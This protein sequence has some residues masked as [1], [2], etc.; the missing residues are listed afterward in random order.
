[1]KLIKTIKKIRILRFLQENKNKK[2][3]QGEIARELI[4]ELEYSSVVSARIV[5][6]IYLDELRKEKRVDFIKIKES[7]IPSK[8]W[9][10][11]SI[12]RGRIVQ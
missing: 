2:F 10:Y 4:D 11:T 6:K 8:K 7:A 9:F 3:S 5:I 1:M 12:Q